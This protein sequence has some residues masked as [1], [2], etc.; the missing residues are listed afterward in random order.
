MHQTS[1]KR[2]TDTRTISQGPL[3]RNQANAR[4]NRK[5]NSSRITRPTNNTGSKSLSTNKGQ[6]NNQ[7]LT[8]PLQS[9]TGELSQPSPTGQPIAPK[10][11]TRPQANRPPSKLSHHRRFPMRP[12][13]FEHHKPNAKAS[14]CLLR[15]LPSTSK[16][17][18][19]STNRQ[20]SST[21]P[22]LHRFNINSCPLTTQ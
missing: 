6:T 5:R 19:I 8:R 14:R 20:H 13:M 7:C 16:C 17:F 18:N 4:Q 2:R 21:T 22:R 3:R 11:H 12:Q 9:T 10:G 15:G 1:S